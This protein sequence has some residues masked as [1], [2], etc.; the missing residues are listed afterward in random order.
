MRQA[1]R[2]PVHL[3]SL[4]RLTSREHGWGSTGRQRRSCGREAHG[5]GGGEHAGEGRQAGEPKRK[6]LLESGAAHL[7]ALRHRHVDGAAVEHAAWREGGKG[8]KGRGWG[9]L[10]EGTLSH[11]VADFLLLNWPVTKFNVPYKNLH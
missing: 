2:L 1:G 8:D 5:S 4:L 10:V 9:G 7:L 3:V 11:E 6:L